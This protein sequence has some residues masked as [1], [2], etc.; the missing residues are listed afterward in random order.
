[1]RTTENTLYLLLVWLMALTVFTACSKGGDDYMINY[2]HD[3]GTTGATGGK[4]EKGDKGDFEVYDGEWTVNKQVVDT[5]R[6]ELSGMLKLR[7]P[8]AYL[9]Q[10]CFPDRSGAEE[11]KPKGL[12]MEAKL[13]AQG[14]SSQMELYSFITKI[15]DSS[16]VVFYG[17]GYFYV[18][19]DGADYQIDLLCSESGSVIF[20]W[21]TE[22]WTI[23]IPIKR[24]LI[25]NMSTYKVQQKPLSTPV[26][27]YYNTKQRIR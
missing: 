7:L 6:L 15:D 17:A 25:T 19:M 24:V 1:M 13:L 27:I 10:L 3:K 14:G 5:A 8:E 16:G 4:G 11:P 2:Y 9:T 26:T 22:M 12:P 18:T 23:G 21:D 20:R